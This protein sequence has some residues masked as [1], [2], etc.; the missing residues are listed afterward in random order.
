MAE[1]NKKKKSILSMEISLGG[2][3]NET[4]KVPVKKGINFIHNDRH[5]NNVHALIYFAVFL[6]VLGL[7][8]YFGIIR[9]IQKQNQAE[10]EYNSMQAQIDDLKNS[11]K[12]YDAVAKEYGL[13]SGSFMSAD[14]VKS[15]NRMEI[16]AM[17]DDDIGSSISLS[18]IHITGNNVSVNT[19]ETNLSTVSSVLTKLQ[20]DDRNSYATVTTTEADSSSDN[21]QVLADFE[22]TYKGEAEDTDQTKSSSEKL[23]VENAP[24]IA[25]KATRKFHKRDCEQVA[26]ID[27]FNKVPFATAKDALAEGYVADEECNPS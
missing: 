24:F 25:D 8:T 20:Q 6:V 22:I 12:D 1:E 17:V 18:D 21:D 5:T 4:V 7:F 27:D 16:L 26:Q 13:S 3:K 2:K 14:E 19:S 15:V 23:T 11:M 9:L 10:A